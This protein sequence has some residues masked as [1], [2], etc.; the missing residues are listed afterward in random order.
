MSE[1]EP[2][3]QARQSINGATSG[4]VG[5]PH[6]REEG[7]HEPFER[8]RRFVPEYYRPRR[9]NSR[10]AHDADPS[11]IGDAY[12]LRPLRS[13]AIK[14]LVRA[15]YKPG[16]SAAKDLTKALEVIQRELEYLEVGGEEL[17]EVDHVVVRADCG[18]L[19]DVDRPA[20]WDDVS[21]H[22]VSR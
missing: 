18:I 11:D 16:Q 1:Q 2:Q 14:Y 9:R 20:S 5:T 13:I 7:D 3:Y 15:G 10:I 21:G 6:E 17:A 19:G 8:G 4:V 22:E 12:R